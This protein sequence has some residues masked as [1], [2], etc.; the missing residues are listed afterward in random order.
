MI[1]AKC[2]ECGAKTLNA[3]TL[4]GFASCNHCGKVFAPPSEAFVEQA[5]PVMLEDGEELP[6]FSAP[7]SADVVYGWRSWGVRKATTKAGL[8]VLQS[9]THREAF[10]QPRATMEAVCP[11]STG[12]ANGVAR[13]GH[14]VPDSHCSCGLYSAKNRKHLMT[15]GYHRYGGDLFHVIGRV[16]LWG[17][18]IE[19]S[20]GWR[21]QFGYP[22]ELYLPFEAWHLAEQL[23]DAYGVPV[24]LSNFLK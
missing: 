5:D 12:R 2:P 13:K 18:V 7:D 19:G 6:E 4:P 10:W 11:R 14:E 8:T 16:A 17:K 21:S 23:E 3:S 20:Q 9:I 1:D 24:A 15:M 22:A